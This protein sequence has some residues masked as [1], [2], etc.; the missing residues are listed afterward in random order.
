MTVEERIQKRLLRRKLLLLHIGL[1]I[2]MT[3]ATVWAVEIFNLPSKVEDAVIPVLVLLMLAH[4]LWSKYQDTSYRII[5]E[6]MQRGDLSAHYEKPKHHIV[7]D[8]DGEL[9]EIMDDEAP[10]VKQKR[11]E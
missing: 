4:A 7:I 2:L 1:T 10:H 6:E 5:Q 11:I 3:L 8:D 9:T